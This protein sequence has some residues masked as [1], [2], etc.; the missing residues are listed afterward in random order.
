MQKSALDLTSNDF[1][2][3]AHEAAV[4]RVADML[5][6]PDDL[7]NKLPMLCKKVAMERASV[8][9]QLKTV[10]EVQLNSM[11]K[12][13][14]SVRDSR[15]QTES[16][17]ESLGRMDLLCGDSQ[18]HIKNYYHIRKLATAHQN[19]QGTKRLVEQFQQVNA[20]MLRAQK[21]LEDDSRKTVGPAKNL[22]LVHNLI[23]DL[24][25]FRSKTLQSAR[26]SSSD[27]LN[28]LNTMFRK[29]EHIEYRF[30][31]YLWDL[32]KNTI[33]LVNQ[34]FPSAVVRMIKLIE[35][36]EK[37]D[38]IIA[39]EEI[40]D[41]SLDG[42]YRKFKGYRIKY[43][44]ILR[45]Q[46]LADMDRMY[47]EQ[48]KD[49]ALVLK[50]V[51]SVVDTLIIV[52]HEITPLFPKR[53]NIFHFYVLEYHR[54]IYDLV[55]TMTDGDIDPSAIL[56][57]TRW[58]Q[59]YYSNMS[60]RLDV[61]E[62]LLEPRILDGREEELMQTYLKLVRSKLAEWLQNI[63]RTE[64]AEF[65][66]RK[67]PP[68]MDTNGQFLLTGS[69]IV[70]Q[71]FNQQLDVV[72]PSSRGQLLADLVVECCNI[73]EQFQN[74]WTE[75]LNTE[76]TRFNTK[77]HEMPEGI[78]EYTMA[79]VNDSMRS[80]EFS[81][82]IVSRLETMCDDQYKQKVIDLVKKS[83]DGFLKI[84]KNAQQ[85]LVDIIFS[86]I[87]VAV[88]VMHCDQWYEQD[89]MKLIIGTFEDYCDDFQKHMSDYTFNKL[90][91]ELM[92]KF[93]VTYL[94]TFKSKNAKFKMPTATNR[95]R[96]D[97]EHAIAYF[98]KTKTA[99]RVTASFEPLLKVVALIEAN[100]RMMYLDF[101]SLWR[102]YPDIP[103]DYMEKLLS[104]RDDLEKAEIKDLI[105]TC[106]NKMKDERMDDVT[107]SIF[108][109]MK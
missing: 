53:Y 69:V 14:D 19:F 34:G 109:K 62:D 81:E 21:L 76:V 86:D 28:T 75:I 107:P 79:L 17:K 95:M 18:N 36:E 71:M 100:P 10:M 22:L 50:A 39:S 44:D 29:L 63:L 3:D 7:T 12:G 61:N 73:L 56:I 58:V 88:K 9:A 49:L 59:D 77:P 99:K 91:T 41:A 5:R 64:T 105:E 26:G 94:E 35:F 57:L 37:H 87:A 60:N 92:D 40:A 30:E 8:E 45:E 42:A 104:K 98:S 106:K 15:C 32:A 24:A 51:D 90:T 47:N 84:A 33:E 80:A 108:S 101:Y 2:S 85:V 54:A 31:N 82:T 83:L 27:V 72:A 78:V 66:V 89:I 97:L 96:S 25:A 13:I 65:I 4:L 43:F 67:M 74:A 1:V 23:S 46:I 68:D 16:I 55:N 102:A 103:L 20:H 6:H 38:E 93:L 52:K 48:G 70:F 11:Q